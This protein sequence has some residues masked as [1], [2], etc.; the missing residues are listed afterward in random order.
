MIVFKN[1][2]ELTNWAY[3]QFD[4]YNVQRPEAYT[5]QELIDS[6]PG[7]PVSFIKQHVKSR[8]NQ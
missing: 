8:D 7:V 5:E 4:K 3:T 6:N 2:K 1:K